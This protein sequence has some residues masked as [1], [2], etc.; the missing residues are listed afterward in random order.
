MATSDLPDGWELLTG[1]WGVD[2]ER[3]EAVVYSGQHSIK[4]LGVDN[5]ALLSPPFPLS[6]SALGASY[7]TA[8]YVYPSRIN[9]GDLIV[10]NYLF[11]DEAGSIISDVSVWDE[12]GYA[13]NA[14]NILGAWQQSYN[15]NAT[16][17]RIKISIYGSTG[18]TCYL[19][20][21]VCTQD[22]ASGEVDSDSTA[23]PGDSGY[24]TVST[25]SVWTPVPAC[26]NSVTRY[27]HDLRN[28]ETRV[29]TCTRAGS[30][31]ALQL[32]LPGVYLIN[33]RADVDTVMNNSKEIKIR[34]ND[35]YSYDNGITSPWEGTSIQGQTPV[36][37]ASITAT[38]IL[39]V[40]IQKNVSYDLSPFH[41][42]VE[43]W[44]NNT[45]DVDFYVTLQAVRIGR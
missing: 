6:S 31:N 27:A 25:P 33:A 44:H 22:P 28:V 3:S 37:D 42:W 14:W 8:A 9:A 16:K 17:A 15:A 1:V 26:T 39:L 21:V 40:P 5:V 35:T 24:F 2:V 18:F 41:V 34:I 30:I 12:P 4:V 13:A 45:V 29:S 32:L 43:V 38:V 7:S 20:T 10:I 11:Y 19:D 23:S 36:F